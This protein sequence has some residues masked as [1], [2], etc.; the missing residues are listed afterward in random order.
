MKR[1]LIFLAIVA[2]IL[3]VILVSCSVLAQSNKTEAV[4]QQNMTCYSGGR[5][6]LSQV[7]NE[8]FCTSEY[9][10]GYNEKPEVYLSSADCVIEPV[11]VIQ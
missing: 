4:Y 11:R 6:I 5:V 9:C 2:L 10:Y 1:S 7:F 8:A 3:T